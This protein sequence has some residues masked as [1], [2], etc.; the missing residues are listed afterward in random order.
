MHHFRYD[1]LKRRL[2]SFSNWQ[3]E[4]IISSTSLATANFH[5]FGDSIGA[6][7]ED[8]RDAVRCH[9]CN[10]VINN[11]QANDDPFTEH[12]RWSPL[13]QFINALGKRDSFC[14]VHKCINAPFDQLDGIAC[15]KCKYT[16]YC[17][18]ECILVQRKLERAKLDCMND[19]Q[20]CIDENGRCK[21]WN[22]TNNSRVQS[23][24]I[25]P[26]GNFV[27]IMPVKQENGIVSYCCPCECFIK[28]KMWI[29]GIAC[30]ECRSVHY[31][32]CM[33]I[34]HQRNG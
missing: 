30:N 7:R 19:R 3:Y 15:S 17:H 18:C 22:V 28:P 31:C 33:C 14:C 5:Y 9:V 12:R 2:N 6:C 21:C 4:N 32:K 1:L 24:L 10:V 26:A 23:D 29:R 34:S 25:L 20:D 13:C 16:G 8:A 11:W 27:N